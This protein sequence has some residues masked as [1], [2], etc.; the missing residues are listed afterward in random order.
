MDCIYCSQACRSI[1]PVLYIVIEHHVNR[2]AEQ[3]QGKTDD[4]HELT[5]RLTEKDNAHQHTNKCEEVYLTEYFFKYL[6]IH[7]LQSFSP[8]IVVYRTLFPVFSLNR[9][10]SF[11]AKLKSRVSPYSLCTTWFVTIRMMSP[12]RSR[13]MTLL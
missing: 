7:G 10:T 11:F 3:N 4:E 6:F 1:Y 2:S 13:F 12:V 8:E 9:N 5:E